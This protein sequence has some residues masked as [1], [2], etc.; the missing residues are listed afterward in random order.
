MRSQA[1]GSA[2][3]RV[4]AI[5]LLL[6][7]VLAVLAARAG[8]LSTVNPD[9]VDQ[10]NRQIHTR[11]KIPG[12]RGLILDRAHRALAISVEAPSVYAFP[13][14]IEN[15]QK[16]AK[17]LG[18]ILSLDPTALKKRITSRSGF[19]YLG[20]WVEPEQA[21]AIRAL[22]LPGIGI[23]YEPRRTYPTGPMAGPIVGF[24]DIDGKGVRGVEQMMD[25]WLSGEPRTVAVERDARGRV[26][27]SDSVDPRQTAGGDITL[28]I[29]AGLQAQAEALL[30]EAVEASEALGGV[31]ICIEPSTGDILSLAEA[32]GFDPNHFRHIA[33]SKTRSR[34]FV[35]A[36]EPG[37]TF[38]AFLVA[39]ALEADVIRPE[40]EIDTGDGWVRVPG[41]T[42][43]DHHPYGVL[44]PAGVLRFSSNVGA[45]WIAQRLGAEAQHASLLR[46]G[47]S[48]STG[49]GFP[50]ESN[51]IL[52]DWRAW[53]PVDQATVAFGQGLNVT[54][55]QLAMAM[56]ALGNDGIRMKPRLVAAQRAPRGEWETLPIRKAGRAIRPETS[57]TLLKMMQSVVSSEGTGRQAAL[58]GVQVAGKTGT[59]QVLDQETGAY[60]QDRYIAWFAGLAPA[61]NPQ[62]AIVVALDQ[63]MGK[64]HTGGAVAAPLFAKVAAAQLAHQGIM[65]K[66][67]PIPSIKV[68]IWVAVQE[69]INARKHAE[70][71]ATLDRSPRA[72]KKPM[73]IA[74]SRRT[75][76]LR[77]A[78]RHVAAPQPARNTGLP[79]VAAPPPTQRR[80]GPALGNET[81]SRI[82][83]ASV[84]VPDF[85]GQSL[86]DAR[87]IAH[88]EALEVH[89]HGSGSGRVVGQAP[90]A[91]TIVMG[92]DRV[93]ILSFSVHQEEG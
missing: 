42:I 85:R 22:D 21:E 12:A 77:P 93:I 44:D 36:M 83:L 90:A 47:F 31:V 37:S 23:E 30:T 61:E 40:T 15:P 7:L 51:G 86:K 14:L 81:A 71:E 2:A 46:F 75:R 20:R 4:T 43:R 68:P 59:A 60:S 39:A 17:N 66:P 55:I 89:I 5:R 26:L 62:I 91:G 32:P 73:Q 58:A 8:Q 64:H 48:Q 27:S 87:R 57:R 67:E 80:V 19:T 92:E 16:V 33:Y 65:T 53:K 74:R 50:Q 28:T 82:E 76:R 34:A 78:N 52:R 35:D 13:Q 56:A 25:R 11:I 72:A 3:A 1:T 9:A 88:Q 24:A 6:L 63:P 70:K 29:D 54:P 79:P 49:S 41:K 18:D 10:G 38:K 69:R 45:V 84:L